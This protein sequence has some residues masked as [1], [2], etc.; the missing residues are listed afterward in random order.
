MTIHDVIID[1]PHAS[2]DFCA[3]RRDDPYLAFV[4]FEAII[5]RFEAKFRPFFIIIASYHSLIIYMPV[6]IVEIW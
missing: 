5:K 4:T 3:C 2:H 6:K 1:T